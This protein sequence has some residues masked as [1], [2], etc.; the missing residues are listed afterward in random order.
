MNA[1]EQRRNRTESIKTLHMLCDPNAFGE[2]S[3]WDLS[4]GERIARGG[5]RATP[6]TH[7]LSPPAKATCDLDGNDDVMPAWAARRLGGC[8]RI[9][10]HK[11]WWSPL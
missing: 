10:V 3:E 9:A 1:S 8:S 11:P 7:R 4:E 2:P 6:R 5:L